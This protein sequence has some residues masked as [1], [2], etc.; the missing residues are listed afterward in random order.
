[1]EAR[2][3]HGIICL[4]DHTPQLAGMTVRVAVPSALPA[5]FQAGIW[6]RIRGGHFP[7]VIEAGA[8]AAENYC[9][10]EQ[11]QRKSRHEARS[12]ATHK[13]HTM[14]ER[15]NGQFGNSR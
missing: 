12:E 7:F 14:L 6:N 13:R 11:G 5:A 10:E 4:G 15:A 8:T 2:P 9:N 1:M 3:V